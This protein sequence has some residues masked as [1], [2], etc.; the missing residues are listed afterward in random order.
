[1]AKRGRPSQIQYWAEKVRD[2]IP[3][4]EQ[5]SLRHVVEIAEL[6]GLTY[7]QASRAIGFLK[8]QGTE[9]PL[10]TSS[11][12]LQYTLD[13]TLLRSYGVVIDRATLTRMRRYY[14]SVIVPLQKHVPD[15]VLVRSARR[16]LERFMEDVDDL[17]AATAA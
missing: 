1:V 8:D 16:N 7:R 14:K 11:A 13:E 10:Y 2:A 6:C 17:I 4:I 12:G 5:L 9:F 3:A 15:S